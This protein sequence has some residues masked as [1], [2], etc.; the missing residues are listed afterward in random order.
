[1]IVVEQSKDESTRLD[2]VQ[3]EIVKNEEARLAYKNSSKHW[4]QKLHGDVYLS[5]VWVS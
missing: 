2:Q 3:S 1:L 5:I 4:L